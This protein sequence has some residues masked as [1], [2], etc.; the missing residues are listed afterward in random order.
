MSLDFLCHFFG[1]SSVFD[2]ID[3]NIGPFFG[4]FVANCR[5]QASATAC[6]KNNAI[7]EGIWHDGFGVD[8]NSAGSSEDEYELGA[9]AVIVRL[10]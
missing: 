1:T 8:Q 10:R 6:Y 2:V 9:A 4:E 5:S 3:H 7:F